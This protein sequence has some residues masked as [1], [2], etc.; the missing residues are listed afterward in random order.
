M[1]EKYYEG[2]KF[3][4]QLQK[5]MSEWLNY[6]TVYICRKHFALNCRPVSDCHR[7]VFIFIFTTPYNVCV[8]LH[9]VL[10][11]MHDEC[12]ARKHEVLEILVFKTP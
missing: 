1:K 3:F 5:V 4:E 7:N 11:M 12:E 2:F 6:L 8:S 9:G 10:D